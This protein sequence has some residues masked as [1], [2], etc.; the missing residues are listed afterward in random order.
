MDVLAEE[1]RDVPAV[2]PSRPPRLR[3]LAVAAAV[4][5]LAGALTWGGF[6]QAHANRLRED[7]ASYRQFLHAL[8]GQDVRVASLAPRSGIQLQGSAVLYDSDRGQSW[9]LVTVRAL[10]YSKPLTVTL[11]GTGGR[12]IELPRPLEIDRGGSGAAWLVTAADI[13]RLRTVTL[14][15]PDGSPVATGTV[16]EGHPS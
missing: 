8:G 3:W 14:S 12:S 11:S 7:A 4:V 16:G 1:E 10:G 9:V 5:A 2:T 15:G 13:T 6:A